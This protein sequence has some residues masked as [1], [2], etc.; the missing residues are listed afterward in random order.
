MTVS[1]L[2]KQ[3]QKYA[4]ISPDIPVMILDSFNG[5]GTPREINMLPHRREV[6]KDD[7]NEA[8]DCEELVGKTVLVMGYGCY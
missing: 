4:E 1:D 3:L 2:I 8:A 5:G 7:A 6:T